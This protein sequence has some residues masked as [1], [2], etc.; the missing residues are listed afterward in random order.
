[1]IL[2]ATGSEVS[3][4]MAAARSLVSDGLSVRVVSMPS[5]EIFEAQEESYREAILPSATRQ[6][7][8]VEAG[9]VDYWRKWVGLDGHVIG[10]KSFGASAPGGELYKHFGITADAVV[11]AAKAF[12]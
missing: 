7:I 12:N 3:V 2:I 4:A 8:A 6:R 9:H 10:M 11:K 1:M 5:V